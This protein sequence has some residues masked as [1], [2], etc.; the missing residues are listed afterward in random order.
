MTGVQ[1]CALP[2]CS[3][4]LCNAHHLRELTFLEEV[5][6]EAWAGKMKKCLR[7]MKSSADH[8]RGKRKKLAAKLLKY[9]ENRYDR[10]VRE[11]FALHCNDPDPPSQGRRGRKIGRASGRERV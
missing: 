4:G 10:I 1:T 2:I 11:G 9:F 8:F 6:G 7:A 5:H 3:H